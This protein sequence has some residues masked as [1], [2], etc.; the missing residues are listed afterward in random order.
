MAYEIGKRIELTLTLKGEYGYTKSYGW[1]STD[2][3]IYKM[4]DADG[5]VFVWN[6][7]TVMGIEG[8]DAKGHWTFDGVHKGDSFHAKATIKGFGEY[9]GEGQIELTRVKVLAIEHAPEKVYAKKTVPTR[10]E[11]LS[12]LGEGDFTWKMPYRQFKEH[13]A[14]CET[15]TGSYEDTGR[16]KFIT[17][18]IRDGRLKASGVRGEHFSGYE[19]TNAKGMKCT[20]R[21][22]SEENAIKRAN[23]EY[24]NEGWTCTHI[25]SYR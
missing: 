22:V 12:S 1:T 8:T 13:Y 3:T 23:K 21:A 15:L 2:Y 9:K 14:D 11:Q 17:V 4:V 24:P 6:T 20:Y 10:E 16:E 25:Y 7:S 5:T 18:I 19:L